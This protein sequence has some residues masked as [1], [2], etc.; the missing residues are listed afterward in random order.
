MSKVWKEFVQYATRTDV[1]GR[2]FRKHTPGKRILP[3]QAKDNDAKLQLRLDAGEVQDG[4][5]TVYLQV[6]SQAKSGKLKD[7]A[8]K[9]GTHANLAV[10]TINENAAPEKQQE[11][12]EQMLD[13]MGSQVKQNLG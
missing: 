13:D 4:V 1:A 6:N 12:L 5:K 10:G 11:E 7:F 3:P 9:H 2:V 8:N